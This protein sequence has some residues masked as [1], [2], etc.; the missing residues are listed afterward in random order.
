MIDKIKYLPA[1][2]FQILDIAK[3]INAKVIGNEKLQISNIS[4]LEDA[5]SKD[6]TFIDNPKYI[7]KINKTAASACIVSDRINIKRPKD[8]VFLVSKDPYLAYSEAVN[9]FYPERNKINKNKPVLSKDIK[10]NANVSLKNNIHIDNNCFIGSNST[11]G[12]NVIIG[13]NCFIGSNVSISNSILG[14]NVTIQN[15]SVIGSDGFGYVVKGKKIVKISQVGIVKIGDNVE[16]GANCAIDR[17]S[18]TLTEI[19]DGVKI[20]NLVHIAHNVKIGANTLIAGQTG[21]AGSTN[22]GENVLIGG[23]VGIAGHLKIGNNVQIGAQAGI[24]KSIDDSCKVSGTPAID[25]N[26]YL[27]QNILLKKMVKKL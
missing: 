21:I 12:P 7:K 1:G 17:G 10:L 2:P 19:E 4:T 27:K 11:I 6:M 25:L 16:I 8:I 23:Q 20:D 9:I 24:T 3:I 13:K 5:T 22:I 18:L 15:G 26:S 14:K